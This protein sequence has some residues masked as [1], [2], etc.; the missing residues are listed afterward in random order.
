MTYVYFAVRS[1]GIGKKMHRR[2]FL[3][4]ERGGTG[5]TSKTFLWLEGK[6]PLERVAQQRPWEGNDWDSEK[7]Q[8]E[9]AAEKRL[10]SSKGE[11]DK[12][13]SWRD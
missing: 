11:G 13:R 6:R 1:E 2:D 4:G 12:P 7:S 5:F 8:L 3:I 10:I 9:G